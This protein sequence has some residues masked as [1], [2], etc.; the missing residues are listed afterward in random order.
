MLATDARSE[1]FYDGRK[2]RRQCVNVIDQPGLTAINLDFTKWLIC[3]NS[4]DLTR[5]NSCDFC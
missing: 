4:Y 5:T 3:T 1:F 2:F